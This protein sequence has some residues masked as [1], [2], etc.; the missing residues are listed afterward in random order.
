VLT[1]LGASGGFDPSIDGP[2]ALAVRREAATASA[3]L[4]HGALAPDE[5]A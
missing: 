5:G 4:G 2:I 3:L 1:A